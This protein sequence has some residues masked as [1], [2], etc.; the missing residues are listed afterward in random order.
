M[1]L[2]I[3][4]ANY[5]CEIVGKSAA[6]SAEID[7]KTLYVLTTHGL[8]YN[9]MTLSFLLLIAELYSSLAQSCL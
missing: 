1:T 4:V 5:S 3:A 9:T 8:I 2:R 6:S 7:F